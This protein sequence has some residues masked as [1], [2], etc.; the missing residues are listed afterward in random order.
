MKWCKLVC[1]DL[2]CGLM[3]IRYLFL[4]PVFF[5]PCFLCLFILRQSGI[6]G[7]LMDYLAYCF[8]GV[9]PII[10]SDSIEYLQLPMLW[11]LVM[12]S[13]MLLN[14]DYPINDLTKNG[15]QVMIRCRSRRAWYLSK[16]IWNII[17]C[18][19][20]FAICGLS[21]FVF[22]LCTNYECSILNTSDF[23]ALVLSA[24]SLTEFNM[25]RCIVLSVFCPLINLIALSMLQMTISLF[26]KPILS[27][28]AILGVLVLSVYISSPLILGNG[29]MAIRSYY[30]CA[31]G[32]C[33]ELSIAVSGIV[34]ILCVIIGLVIFQRL[35]IL[36][37]R[38]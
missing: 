29:A 38:E 27:F 14:L 21:C 16:C 26:V 37:T 10:L 36:G 12:G 11:L 1:Y 22:M 18:V 4:F 28:L 13:C 34:V 7:S 19:V 9:Q 15:Q 20:F 31:G 3:R 5:I 30:I 6:A 35:D 25:S 17:S 32:I 24:A 8:K 2:R 23:M 33:S